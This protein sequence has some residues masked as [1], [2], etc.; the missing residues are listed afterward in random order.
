MGAASHVVQDEIDEPRARIPSALYS[1]QQGQM[2]QQKMQ[3]A[4]N[5]QIQDWCKNHMEQMQQNKTKAGAKTYKRTKQTRKKNAANTKA[6]KALKYLQERKAQI[7][8]TTEVHQASRGRRQSWKTSGMPWVKW[9]VN[10]KYMFHKWRFEP[11][12]LN[13]KQ[14]L[15]ITCHFTSSTKCSTL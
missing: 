2:M 15:D 4:A 11:K 5:G 10:Q 8:S 3:R 9:M 14:T 6:R 7:H 13:K 12:S 1:F